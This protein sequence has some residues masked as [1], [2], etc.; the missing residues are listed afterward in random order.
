[1]SS[2]SQSF[3]IVATVALLLRPLTMLLRVD[4]VTPLRVAS[5]LTLMPRWAHKSKIRWRTAVLVSV[6]G[7]R[8]N[9]KEIIRV[10][11]FLPAKINSFELTFPWPYAI[12]H[13]EQKGQVSP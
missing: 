13:P 6:M 2:P 11:L 7:S 8:P 10:Y 1:M 4:W 12:L 3:L 5:R 9:S